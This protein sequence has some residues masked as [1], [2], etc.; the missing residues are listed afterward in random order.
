MLANRPQA[1]FPEYAA[2]RPP[3]VRHMWSLAPPSAQYMN[4]LI[5]SSNKIIIQLSPGGTKLEL[6]AELHPGFPS[7]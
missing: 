7:L 5:G 1:F 3:G 6:W 4:I 2:V